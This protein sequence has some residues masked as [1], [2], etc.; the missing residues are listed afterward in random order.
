MCNVE[1]Q[2]LQTALIPY[3]DLFSIP[4]KLTNKSL[5]QYFSLILQDNNENIFLV[6]YKS[7]KCIMNNVQGKSTVIL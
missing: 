5:P 3:S 4:Y 2:I 7:R 1:I 6:H